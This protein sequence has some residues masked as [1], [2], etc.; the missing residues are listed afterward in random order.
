MAKQT[1]KGT[2]V[3]LA[4]SGVGVA[5]IGASKGRFS[6]VYFHPRDLSGYRGETW[7][8]LASKGLTPGRSLQM[9]VDM[10]DSGAVQQVSSVRITNS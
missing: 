5:R 2:L 3:K 6:F 9:D 10:D 4:D 7:S 1:I 8:E